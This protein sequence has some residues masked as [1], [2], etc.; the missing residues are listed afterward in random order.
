MQQQRPACGIGQFLHDGEPDA[1][2]RAV[3]VWQLG[4]H[5]VARGSEVVF[6]RLLIDNPLN[7]IVVVQTLEDLF[8]ES[9]ELNDFVVVDQ[10]VDAGLLVAYEVIPQEVSQGAAVKGQRLI[11]YKAQELASSLC[12]CAISEISRAMVS[13][14]FCSC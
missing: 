1:V 10:V 8:A 7:L 5:S 2:L 9:A 4:R 14:L 3:V 13:R 11:L 12:H 6:D